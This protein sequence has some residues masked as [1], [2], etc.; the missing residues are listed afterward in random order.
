MK[1][2]TKNVVE[3]PDRPEFVCAGRMVYQAETNEPVPMMISDDPYQGEYTDV[4]AIVLTKHMIQPCV[5]AI[6]KELRDGGWVSSDVERDAL[7][8]AVKKWTLRVAVDEE[9]YNICTEHMKLE[10]ERLQ[11]EHQSA[12]RRAEA[13]EE[14]QTMTLTKLARLKNT[15]A[16]HNFKPWWKRWRKI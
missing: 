6:E 11:A 10:I 9:V 4:F 15:V 12:V 3:V 14:K 16:E 2:Y 5:K 8:G 7:R 13:A 1:L